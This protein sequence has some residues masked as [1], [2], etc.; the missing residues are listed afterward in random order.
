M[1]KQT[2]KRRWIAKLK[3]MKLIPLKAVVEHELNKKFKT[4]QQH[5]SY[6]APEADLASI[7]IGETKF[8][9][10]SFYDVLVQFNKNKKAFR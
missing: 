9:N 6:W 4:L 8:A 10:R 2:S 5:G 3:M 7:A 1:K